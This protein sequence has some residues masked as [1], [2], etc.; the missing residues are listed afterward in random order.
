MTRSA[1]RTL[2]W[3]D[4]VL[5]VEAGAVAHGGHCVARHEGRVLFVRHAL[6]GETVRAVVT[7]DQGGSFCLADAISV[8]VASPDRVEAPCPWARAGGCGG[9]DFQHVSPEAQRALKTTVLREQ[10]SRLG[11]VESEVSVEELPGGALGWRQRIR[12]AVD[13]EG[14]AGLRAHHSHEVVPIA[15]CLLAPSGMLPDLLERSWPAGSHVEVAVDATGERRIGTR[16]RQRAAGREWDLSP[17]AFWQVHPHLADALVG[18]VREWAAAPSG[19]TA[20][21]LY[22]GVGLFAAVL[23]E[24]VGPT[25]SVAVVES[26]PAAVADGKRALADLPQV[27][28]REGRVEQVVKGLPDPSVV[29]ADPPRKGLQKQMVAAI[30]DR[31]PERVVYVAC[32]PASLGRDVTLFAA[33]GYGLAEVRSFDAFPMTHHMESV[34]LFTRS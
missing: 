28:F 14:R 7:D 24:Q 20:W 2:D 29:V 12:L 4:R 33:R 11:G 34:A 16:S 21:D 3:T 19:G 25:G 8:L 6:P 9:C 15:D 31:A 1:D 18:V 32:D 23:G 5:E 27:W 13:D 22:G 17:G 26:S 30:C 10:L